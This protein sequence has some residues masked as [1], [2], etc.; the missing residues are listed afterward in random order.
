[1][2]NKTMP[3]TEPNLPSPAADASAESALL[4][5]LAEQ[6]DGAALIVDQTLNILYANSKSATAL[7]VPA[8]TLV[9][10]SLERMIA[11]GSRLVNNTIAPRLKAA[12]R[13]GEPLTL[14]GVCVT[15][16]D[17]DVSRRLKLSAIPLRHSRE[18][19]ATLIKLDADPVRTAVPDVQRRLG[20]ALRRDGRGVWEWEPRTGSFSEFRAGPDGSVVATT[21]TLALLL[22]RLAPPDRDEA[23]AALHRYADGVGP[24]FSLRCRTAEA[25]ASAAVMLIEG[26][27]KYFDRQGRLEL[28]CGTYSDVTDLAL[29]EAHLRQKTAD[30]STALETARQGL[31]EW[32][33]VDNRFFPSSSWCELFGYSMSSQDASFRYLAELAHPDEL[34][35]TREKLVA[36]LQGES[37]IYAAEQ[38][39]RHHCGHYLYCLIRGRVTERDASGRALRMV[40][41]HT[42]VSELKAARD[43]LAEKNRQLETVL[44]NSP[45]GVW[46]WL[47]Q[48]DQFSEFGYLRFASGLGGDM[49]ITSGQQLDSLTHPDDIPKNRAALTACLKG[50]TQK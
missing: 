13:Q 11:L 12:I 19:A 33:A 9:G 4:A 27:H 30:L 3:V 14:G 10:E 5:E 25:P 20:I 49:R 6:L 22:N 46:E 44:E 48:T 47:P 31:W 50:E 37:D 32:D 40:G 8:A 35:A 38:S 34:D 1:M 21:A 24:R 18:C 16:G 36:V 41:T 2:P 29:T 42:D 23:A 28:V 7:D 45:H 43:A 39:V 17:R 26:T 15:A